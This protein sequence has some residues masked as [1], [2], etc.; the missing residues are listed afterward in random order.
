MI[1]KLFTQ[2]LVGIAVVAAAA[3]AW[4]LFHGGAEAAFPTN[5][6]SWE[7]HDR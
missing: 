6:S 1:G 5:G 2:G 7:E 4:S 3:W